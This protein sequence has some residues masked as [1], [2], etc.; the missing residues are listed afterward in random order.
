MKKLHVGGILESFV[1]ETIDACETF[2]EMI[3]TTFIGQR[4]MDD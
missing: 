2:L 3:K 4:R 1:I